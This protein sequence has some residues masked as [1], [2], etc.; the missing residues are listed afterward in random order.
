MQ[1]PFVGIEETSLGDDMNVR[2]GVF[3]SIRGRARSRPKKGFSFQ[4]V[5]FICG[6]QN[7]EH[8]EAFDEGRQR[9]L[10]ADLDVMILVEQFMNENPRQA[11]GDI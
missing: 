6:K 4:T 7:S 9:E 2:Q 3:E 11:Q 8:F 5:C 1:H 10:E